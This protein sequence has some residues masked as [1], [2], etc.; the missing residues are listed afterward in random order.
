MIEDGLTGYSHAPLAVSARATFAT[1]ATIATF[2]VAGADAN[3][4]KAGGHPR[5]CR[6]AFAADFTAT[7][8][9]SIASGTISAST[10]TAADRVADYGCIV[11][12]Q[13]AGA[14]DAAI[15]ANATPA[16][17]AGCRCSIAAIATD[18]SCSSFAYGYSNI[19]SG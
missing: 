4:S 19:Y 13:I 15:L 10:R 1:L 3:R 14:E 18:T 2:A 5:D 11:K 7:A 9:T 17:C 6:T 16:L 8:L 12:A